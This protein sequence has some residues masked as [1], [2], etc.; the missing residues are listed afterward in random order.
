MEQTTTWLCPVCERALESK[1][2]IV[3]GYFDEILKQTPESVEDVMVE[4][5]GEWHTSDNKYASTAWKASHPASTAPAQKPPSIP[6]ARAPSKP[7]VDG[8]A[9]TNQ[10]IFV[11]DSDDEDEGQVKRELSPSLASGS[12]SL[13]GG[14]QTQSQPETIDLTLDSDDDEPPPKQAGK[15]KATDSDLDSPTEQIWKKSRVEQLALRAASSNTGTSHPTPSRN[16]GPIPP[17]QYVAAH[18]NLISPPTTEHQPYSA[19][20]N[21]STP[22]SRLPVLPGISA[23][24][25]GNGPWS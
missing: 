21:S 2:L 5:D 7:E 1:D 4:A 13:S 9:K 12:N 20:G 23:M 11:L 25:P 6:Q 15:R 22:S 18:R 19:P 3:D 16:S 10:E 24:L 8:K 17:L 14:T